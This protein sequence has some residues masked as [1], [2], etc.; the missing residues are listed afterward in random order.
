M[1]VKK[2]IYTAWTTLDGYLGDEDDGMSWV[3]GDDQIRSTRSA[4]FD[5]ADI[6]DAR[7]KVVPSRRR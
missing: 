5:S 3:R 1:I 4:S 6:A 2:L 7:A